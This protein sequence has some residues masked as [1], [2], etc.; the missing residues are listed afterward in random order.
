M[1]QHRRPIWFAVLATAMS[2]PLILALLST[3]AI[4][5][6]GSSGHFESWAALTGLVAFILPYAYAAML[7]FALPYILWL[8]ARRELTWPH[9]CTGTVV[10]SLIA[11][12]AY[13]LLVAPQI[14][15]GGAIAVLSASLG[16]L[17]GVAFCLAAGITFRPSR[18]AAH[19][20]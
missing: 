10:A 15:A 7:V 5:L 4:R 12:P 1:N 8:R 6:A 13:S 19:A 18:R 3:L 17:S 16:L 11:V 2:V 20:A 14:Q 9:V